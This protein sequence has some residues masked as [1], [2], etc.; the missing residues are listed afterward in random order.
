MEKKGTFYRR[1]LLIYA[2]STSIVFIVFS[3]IMGTFIQK[4][5]MKHINDLNDKALYQSANAC[6]TTLSNL[7][8][9]YFTG[10]LDSPEMVELMLADGYSHKLSRSFEKLRRNMMNYSDLV[11]SCYVINLKSGFVCSTN[12]TYKEIADFTDRDILEWL[13]GAEES[14]KFFSFVPRT[15]RFEIAGIS[16]EEKYLSFISKKY[17]EGFLVLN[18]DYEAFADMINYRSY[19][20]QSQTILVGEGGYVLA[21]SSGQLFGKNI[22]NEPYYQQLWANQGDEGIYHYTAGGDKQQINYRRNG[23]F[24]IQYLTLTDRQLLNDGNTLLLQ[25]IGFS[26]VAVLINLGIIQLAAEFLYRPIGALKK[27]VKKYHGEEALEADEFKSIEKAV[28]AL[29]HK[30]REYGKTR[31]RNVLRKLL[32]DQVIDRTREGGEINALNADLG[33]VSFLVCNFYFDHGMQKDDD[34]GIFKF[35]LKNIFREMM[36]EHFPVKLVEYNL[37]LVAVIGV[38]DNCGLARIPEL[39][40]VI[41]ECQN[42]MREYYE[43][44]VSASLGTMVSSLFDLSESY[45]QAIMAEFYQPIGDGM[46]L[47]YYEDLKLD[48]ELKKPYPAGLVEA[49]MAGIKG[50]NKT[51]TKL[52]ISAFYSEVAKYPYEQA[53]KYICLLDMEIARLK[54]K[55]EIELPDGEFEILREIVNRPKLFKLQEK[56]VKQCIE[57]IDTYK[58]TKEN[59]SSRHVI[60]ERIYQTVEE[61]IC[62][63]DLSVNMIAGEVF[64]ST[65]YLR[66]IF[67]DVTGQTLSNYIIEKRLG[68]ICRLLRETKLSVPEISDYM[69]FTSKNYLHKFFKNYMGQTP[70]QYRKD[71]QSQD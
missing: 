38:E 60:V 64:L 32:E 18:L 55:L 48:E 28:H 46:T 22:S 69:G 12:D 15:A 5:Y 27:V 10:I 63:P 3:F 9:Y 40:T 65:S 36:A 61:N 4:N 31:Q 50:A 70:I 47:A 34:L 2:V 51:E 58:E 44:N 7:Y 56:C 17:N 14:S 49:V 25:A 66:N 45:R 30:S 11:S 8:N 19:N 42:R 67:K 43:V 62:N 71:N 54:I 24:G 57:L 33:E 1:M 16:Y 52:A 29:N 21:D 37:Y 41:I 20:P 59:D 39:E 26:C 6:S 13:D 35:A 68:E 23:N 53:V